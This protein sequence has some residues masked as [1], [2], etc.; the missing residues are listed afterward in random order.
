M[1][2]AELT[3]QPW[4]ELCPDVGTGSLL[5]AQATHGSEYGMAPARSVPIL[6]INCY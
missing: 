5:E 3:D 4:E 6:G 2:P 1:S